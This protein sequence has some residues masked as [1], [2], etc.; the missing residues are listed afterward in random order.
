MTADSLWFGLT[1][2]TQF[3]LTGKDRASFLHNFCTQEING[4]APGTATEAFLTNHQARVLAWIQVAALEDRLRVATDPSLGE[5]LVTYLNRFI[6]SEEVTITDVSADRTLMLATGPQTNGV[7]DNLAAGPVSDLKFRQHRLTI[8]A[9]V[10][11]RVERLNWLAT[12]DFW[13]DLPTPQAAALALHLNNSG[14]QEGSKLEYDRRRIA[15]GL[16]VYGRD[17]DE[18]SLPQEADRTDLAISFTKGCYVGQETVARIRA[19][20]HVNGGLCR[21]ELLA[22]PPGEPGQMAGAKLLRDGTEVGKITSFAGGPEPLG[23]RAL[24][25]VRR[26]SHDAGIDLEANAAGTTLGRV[27]VL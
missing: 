16:P 15:A 14:L 23:R 1:G 26:G 3:E 13:L 8:L 25:W 5:K 21:L 6:V 18:S 19:Y 9:G 11:V 27:R 2:W 24:G 12:G 7:L 17:L 10:P 22:Y 4:L 20:G